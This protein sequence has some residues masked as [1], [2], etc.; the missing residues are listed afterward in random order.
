M[1]IVDTAFNEIFIDFNNSATTDLGVEGPTPTPTPT[2]ATPATPTPTVTPTEA[3]PATPTPTEA[4]PT[5]TPTPTE[6]TPT[7]T[8]TEAT[9]TVTPT[10]ATPVTPTP[11]TPTPTPTEVTPATPTPTPVDPTPTPVPTPTAEPTPTVGPTETPMPEPRATEDPSDWYRIVYRR[12]GQVSDDIEI[13][14]LGIV[15]PNGLPTDTLQIM[16]LVPQQLYLPPIT[17]VDAPAGLRV[18]V[19]DAP[20]V[21]VVSDGTIDRMTLRNY[22]GAISVARTQSIR[23]IAPTAYTQYT[24][25]T[26]ESPYTRPSAINLVGIG[27]GALDAPDVDFTQVSSASRV[28]AAFD[29]GVRRRFLSAGSIGDGISDINVSSIRNLAAMGASIRANEINGA[30]TNVSAQGMTVRR[31]G[32]DFQNVSLAGDIMVNELNSSASGVRISAIGGNILGGDFFVDGQIIQIRA[33]ARRLAGIPT[34][35][36]LGLD[37]APADFLRV[38]SGQAF[39]TPIR[40]EADINA[41]IGQT[42]VNGEFYAGGQVDFVG[43][44]TPTFAGGVRGVNAAR[45][46]VLEGVIFQSPM[47]SQNIFPAPR[48]GVVNNMTIVTE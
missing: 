31:L 8:P 14:T 29:K 40:N 24:D 32:S 38:V 19:S 23:V 18:L 42:G 46:A 20:I 13:S 1:S 45:G 28:Y 43:N 30:I 41:I 34:G 15:I 25:I 48:R 4:T 37:D 26:I 27:L 3:T 22:V 16:K 2:E 21:D 6:A 39:A 5:V 12:G 35:G 33:L 36:F 7:V 9:P 11:V 17:L 47:R 10:E 44:I